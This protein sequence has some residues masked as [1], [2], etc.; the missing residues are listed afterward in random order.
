MG[1]ALGRVNLANMV[2]KMCDLRGSATT[3]SRCR[4]VYSERELETQYK[5]LKGMREVDL[6]NSKDLFRCRDHSLNANQMTKVC[7]FAGFA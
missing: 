2:Y 3:N 4:L 1:A 7:P 5:I 6:M